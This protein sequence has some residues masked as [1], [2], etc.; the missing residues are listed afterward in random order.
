MRMHSRMA[1]AAMAR[2]TGGYACFKVNTLIF[3]ISD[4]PLVMIP[5]RTM[6]PTF[7]ELDLL[8][9]KR[10]HAEFRK[11]ES[12]NIKKGDVLHSFVLCLFRSTV[13]TYASRHRCML[14]GAHSNTWKLGI[15]SSNKICK[16]TVVSQRRP[17]NSQKS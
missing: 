4:C 15:I 2:S 10:S 9:G 11:L 14:P 5:E 17:R 1:R 8:S 16:T 7:C 13:Y 12:G 6:A 3:Q